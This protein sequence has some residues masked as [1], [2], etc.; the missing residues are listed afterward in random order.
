M[1]HV[2]RKESGSRRRRVIFF[3]VLGLSLVRVFRIGLRSFRLVFTPQSEHLIRYSFDNPLS[4]THH[5][6]PGRPPQH[7]RVSI[8]L[9]LS[10]NAWRPQKLV[11]RGDQQ[12]LAAI[13]L[14]EAY[15]AELSQPRRNQDQSLLD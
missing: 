4:H 14:F 1:L 3:L 8:A 15:G 11:E 10:L 9:M 12:I 13:R 2:S 5:I 6:V 7:K